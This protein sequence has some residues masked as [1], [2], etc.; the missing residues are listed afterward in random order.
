MINTLSRLKRS[1][2]EMSGYLI[3]TRAESIVDHSWTG[4]WRRKKSRYAAPDAARRCCS[5]RAVCYST[6][7]WA[8][9]AG[10]RHRRCWRRR[11]ETVALYLNRRLCSQAVH[12]LNA[13]NEVRT[14]NGNLSTLRSS[15]SWWNGVRR[16]VKKNSKKMPTSD[17]KQRVSRRRSPR[18]TSCGRFWKAF[19]SRM[20][21]GNPSRALFS[22]SCGQA[23]KREAVTEA[24][25]RRAAVVVNASERVA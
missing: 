17:T 22:G 7:D 23:K 4:L 9:T 15:L 24:A 6:G 25:M 19:F 11:H 16:H 13:V 21:L 2:A 3:G 5:T 1:W 10:G 14:R 8:N 18:E 12:D 20:I